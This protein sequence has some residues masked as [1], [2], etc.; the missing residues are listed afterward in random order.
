MIYIRK[1]YLTEKKKEKRKCTEYFF[2]YLSPPEK[3]G[4]HENTYAYFANLF[5]LLKCQIKVR[6][7]YKI[8]RSHYKH[9][10]SYQKIY[11]SGESASRY[12]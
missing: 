11:E 3:I 7:S 2:D 1:Q 10:K 5:L 6:K 4:C 12:E 9:I 8:S